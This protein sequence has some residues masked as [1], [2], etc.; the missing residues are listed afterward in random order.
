MTVK[1]NIDDLFTR[2]TFLLLCCGNV[3]WIQGD[4]KPKA[5]TKSQYTTFNKNSGKFYETVLWNSYTVQK[6]KSRYSW[7]T[8]VSNVSLPWDEHQWMGSYRAWCGPRALPSVAACCCIPHFHT[9]DI[10][11]SSLTGI[12]I[13]RKQQENL[14]WNNITITNNWV[15]MKARMH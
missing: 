14:Q 3:P 7:S 4:L 13:F 5:I 2:D 9:A 12:I 11:T 6:K 15:C 8:C 10:H 1:G